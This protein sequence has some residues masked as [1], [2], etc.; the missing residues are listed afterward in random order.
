MTESPLGE[1]Q[2]NFTQIVAA[3]TGYI[4]TQSYFRAGKI[5]QII[6]NFPPGCNGLVQMSLYKDGA[7]FYPLTGYLALDDSTPVCYVDADYY[8]K[9]PL[10]LEV[11]NTDASNP[12]AP[13]CTVTIR[14][15]KPN[16][17]SEE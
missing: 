6:F 2:L 14:F 1:V 8:A 17:M 5:T 11:L 12:H 10:M 16:W 4:A 13:T 7:K 3:G 15:T 9:E